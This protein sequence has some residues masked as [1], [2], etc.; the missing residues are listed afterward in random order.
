MK[1]DKIDDIFGDIGSIMPPKIKHAPKTENIK[2]KK[3]KKILKASVLGELLGIYEYKEGLI[4]KLEVR[5]WGTEFH[6]YDG[7]IEYAVNYFKEEL[8]E[9]EYV[10]F[11]SFTPQYSQMTLRQMKYYIHWRTNFRR[12]KCI[13]ADFSYL[14]LFIYEV[15]NIP[16]EY[17]PSKKGVRYL[18]YLWAKYRQQFPQL[19]KY[20]SEWIPDYCL[21]KAVECPMDIIKVFMADALKKTTLPEF[22]LNKCDPINAQAELIRSESEYDFNSSASVNDENRDLFTSHI[23]M[24]LKN[25]FIDKKASGMSVLVSEVRDTYVGALCLYEN[26]RRMTI[27]HYKLDKNLVDALDATEAVKYA[28]SLVRSGL[29]LRTKNLK[30]SLPSA[31]KERIDEYFSEQVTGFEKPSEMILRV[32]EKRYEP[33][34]AGFSKEE[35]EKIEL[36]SRSTAMLIEGDLSKE[37]EGNG[38]SNES[39]GNDEAKMLEESVATEGDALAENIKELFSKLYYKGYGA[40]LDGCRASGV[41][42]EAIIEEINYFAFLKIGDIVL[43]ADGEEY[44]VIQDYTKEAEEWLKK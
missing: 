21:I 4:K 33:E 11:F 37:E 3:G 26:K 40:F 9:A 20:L 16:E 22:Y 27:T 25:C 28:E 1:K 41:L 19:D 36:E 17:L 32:A 31:V 13:K 15:I 5:A 8:E 12:G 39:H 29:G 43:E 14:M 30:Y 2:E 24:A 38:E 42:P 34:S 18:A 23:N 7:F 6:F 35:A 44:K 10:P